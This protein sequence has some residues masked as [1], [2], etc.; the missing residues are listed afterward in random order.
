MLVEK[1]VGNIKET[2][3]AGLKEDR[4]ILDRYDMNKP[5]QKVKTES[6]QSVAISLDHGE[7]LYDGSILYIDEEKVIY[8]E[9]APE[10]LIMVKPQGTRQWAKAAFNIGNMHQAA[11]IHDDFILIPY[12]AIM[13]NV[14]K[15]V[16][17]EYSRCTMKLDGERANVDAGS[18]SH[19]HDH[20]HH[21]HHTH[22]H[23]HHHE[24]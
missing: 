2:D 19:S 20:S 5:H 12:D 6:D 15:A 23:E 17:V 13:E 4:V 14:L 10:D 11:Y 3:H 7:H 21:H 18:H 22:D 24:E 16:G 9:L 8:V 1:I